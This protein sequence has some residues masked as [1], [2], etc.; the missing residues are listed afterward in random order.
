VQWNGTSLPTIYN[1]ATQLTADVAASLIASGGS[2]SVTVQNGGTA[3]SA[4]S[5]FSIGPFTLVISTTTLPDAIV[6]SGYSQ[7]L[8]ATGGSPPYTW[9]VTAGTLPSGIAIDPGSG[10]VSGTAT[11]AVTGTVGF[12]VT[13][14]V[15]RTVTKSIAFRSVAPLTVTTTTP[16]NSAPAGVSFSQ[17]LAATGGTAPY[18]W[19]LTGSLPTGL[20]LNSTTGQISGTPTVPGAYNFTINITDSRSQATSVPFTQTV[21]VAGVTIGGITTTSTS[22]QQLPINVTIANPY[23]VNLNGT[24]TLVFTSAVGASDPAIQFSSGGLTANFTIPAGT[25][26][27]VFGTQQSVLLITGTTAGSIAVTAGLQAA[28]A[29]V[30]PSTAPAIT[31]ESP[32]PLRAPAWSLVSPAIPT[33]AI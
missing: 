29:S 31:L 21:T 19:T 6:G 30:T 3:T 18:T 23:S 25:T 20:S 10:T 4:A 26:Q 11:A 27:A 2:A 24:L 14:S 17:I 28:G 32:S 15:A 22:G 5:T 16:L 33:P 1:S 8:A 9:S 12:T 7:I 13:D